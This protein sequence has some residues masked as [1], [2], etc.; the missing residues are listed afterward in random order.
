[1]KEGMMCYYFS[2][3]N[4]TIKTGRDFRSTWIEVTDD[5]LKKLND[6]EKAEIVQSEVSTD[7]L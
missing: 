5:N 1:M 3:K 7:G 2:R 6:K 4:R